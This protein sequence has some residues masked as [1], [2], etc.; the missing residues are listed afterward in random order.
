M[1]GRVE[2]WISGDPEPHEAM[3][4]SRAISEL[5]NQETRERLQSQRLSDWQLAMYP[6]WTSDTNWHSSG[7]SSQVLERN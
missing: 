6:G 5:I 3:I 4:I 2:L 1:T 7:D